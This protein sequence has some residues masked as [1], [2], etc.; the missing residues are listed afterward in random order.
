MVSKDTTGA[1]EGSCSRLGQD[2]AAFD[3]DDELMTSLDT[4]VLRHRNQNKLFTTMSKLD[5]RQHIATL[6]DSSHCLECTT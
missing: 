5:G 4:F 2:V 3:V 1:P 6:A